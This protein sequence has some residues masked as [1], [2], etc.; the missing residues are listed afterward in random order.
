V[1]AEDAEGQDAERRLAAL[2]A[3]SA[4][5]R[6]CPL[7]QGRSRAVFAD[8]TAKARIFFVGE[9]PGADEDRTGVPFV[10][11]AGQLLT[12]IIERAMGLPRSAVYIANIVKCRPP[13]NR[14]PTKTEQDA[15]A[16][17]FLA[18]QIRLVAPDILIPLGKV[19]AQYLLGS[20]LSMSRMRGRVWDHDGIPVVPT[21]HPAYLLRVPSAKRDTW[22]DIKLALRTLGLDDSPAP[23]TGPST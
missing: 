16:P 18:H 3:Q 10:G 5:C 14:N 1:D 21:W 7:H 11:R 2:A 4:A 22:D 6:A 12:A 20:E 17:Q 8:G 9:G 19:A 23:W 15:C 13:G